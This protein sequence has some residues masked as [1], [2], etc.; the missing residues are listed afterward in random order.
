MS[1]VE[2][3]RAYQKFKKEYAQQFPVSTSS[4][5]EYHAFCTVCSVDFL[6]SHG[7]VND[8]KKHIK[9]KK[10]LDQ[11]K[12]RANTPRIS[13][14]FASSSGDHNVIQAET[15]FTEFIIEHN[16][17]LA[18]ADHASRIFR[19]MF[20]DSEIAKKYGCGRTKTSYIVETLAMDTQQN[21]VE[22]LRTHPFSMSTDGSTDYE[23]VKL[24]PIC[25][26]FCDPSTGKVKSVIFSLEEC[27]EPSTGENIFKI[28]EKELD[29]HEIPW[30]NL[31]C[32]SADNASVMLGKVKG[33]AAYLQRRAPSVF[34]AGN[35]PKH[36]DKNFFFENKLK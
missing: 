7:G 32:F 23:D 13:N 8:I 29:K 1:K 4:L 3:K 2:K 10:H 22:V 21:I 12:V 6:I 30:K 36:V 24:Y 34:I 26:R 5:G 14:F 9:S 31:V 15:L 28:L 25:V 18:V 11:S 27:N 33:V 20:P 35:V 17:P 19:K 16:L